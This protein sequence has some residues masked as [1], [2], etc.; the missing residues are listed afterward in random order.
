MSSYASYD[1]S[2]ALAYDAGR[3]PL[4]LDALI[5]SLGKGSKPLGEMELLDAGCGTAQYAFALAGRVKRLVAIDL[6]SAMLAIAQRK[7][8]TAPGNVH[9]HRGSVLALP[10][11]DGSFDGAMLNQ[12]LHHLEPEEDLRYGAHVRALAEL[13]RVLRPGGV[14]TTTVCTHEQLR[15][16]FWYYHLFPR[17]VQRVLR[18]CIHASLLERLLADLGFVDVERVVPTLDAMQGDLYFD[19]RGPLSP[20]WRRLDSIF[21]LVDVDELTAAESCLRALDAQGHLEAY[22]AE[23]DR[24]RRRV[25]QFTI[26]VARVPVEPA[27]TAGVSATGGKRGLRISVTA[28][29]E[30][31]RT[32]CAELLGLPELRTARVL[33]P[34]PSPNARRLRQIR[35]S[36]ELSDPGA[37]WAAVLDRLAYEHAVVAPNAGDPNP[38]IIEDNRAWLAGWARDCPIARDAAL[39]VLAQLRPPD[40]CLYADILRRFG[41]S[42]APPER[43]LGAPP[44]VTSFTLALDDTSYPMV[45]VPAGGPG[46]MTA[47]SLV[48]RFLAPW[49]PLPP[50]RSRSTVAWCPAAGSAVHT[51]DEPRA[52]AAGPRALP[53]AVAGHG[54]ADR[55]RIVAICGLDGAGK[56]TVVERVAR[57]LHDRG[58]V[59]TSKRVRDNV[60]HVVAT[61]HPAGQSPD[62]Y[63]GGP[64]AQA[65]RWAHGF[66]FLRY[67]EEE[68]LSR[69]ME[70]VTILS[71][72]WT[73]CSVSYSDA[74]THLGCEMDA[75]LAGIPPP[76]LLIY[77][78]VPA[79]EAVRR[80]EVRGDRQGNEGLELLRQCALAYDVWLARCPSPVVR[81]P[82]LHLEETC[83]HVA[84]LV[85]MAGRHSS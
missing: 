80:I 36:A 15:E 37:L 66:D 32:I 25:G 1:E 55:A 26:F 27:V 19:P 46:R 83:R 41:S 13:K 14:L 38:L 43:A 45:P 54:R 2:T 50:D 20:E 57:A 67:Y 33:P 73:I 5:G 7:L 9:L 29:P 44:P 84:A 68:V 4:G 49:A 72:R 69:C 64:F 51:P 39:A 42:D 78:D 11:P 61:F 40:L 53:G 62:A 79:E 31:T 3:V 8:A 28:P 63:F 59:A 18:R 58:V 81:I 35:G 30:E 56:T 60:N 52:S 10:Y 22:A 74:F 16:G 21:E 47:I 48:S 85:T 71:D 77:L 23:H 75:L 24:G 34:P 65:V 17:A 70:D 76:D 6:S 12:V 82:N